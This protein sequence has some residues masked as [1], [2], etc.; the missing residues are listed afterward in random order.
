MKSSWL[1]FIG[2]GLAA[3]ILQIL[4]FR[5]LGYGP[6]EPDVTLIML[7]WVMSTQSRTLSLFFAAYVALLT[8]FFL[9]HWGLSLFSKTVTTLLVYRYIPRKEDSRLFFTQ[10][11]LLIFVISLL[12]NFLYLLAAY[13]SQIYSTH[14]VFLQIL[15][16]SSLLT[17]VIG[18]VIYAL[19]ER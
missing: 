11:F 17:A 15:I 16:G 14:Q 9:D 10:V 12:D 1:P 13:F 5:H 19:A 8:D 3:V 18:S 4:L 6:I 7:I 2:M